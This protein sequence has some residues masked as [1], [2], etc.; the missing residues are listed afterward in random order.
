MVGIRYRWLLAVP[1][2]YEVVVLKT[3]KTEAGGNKA[4]LVR[5]PIFP[6]TPPA[7]RYCSRQCDQYWDHLFSCKFSKTPLHNAIQNTM[8]ILLST[9]APL[10]GLV[11]NKFDIL[12]EP[13]NLL[14]PMHPLRRPVDIAITLKSPTNSKSTLL[15]INVSTITPVPPH[16]HSQPQLTNTSNILEAHLSSIRGKLS[17]QTHGTLSNQDVITAINQEHITLH[18]RR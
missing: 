13:T 16:L 7:C 12:L 15:A 4:D 18:Q 5:L 6:A 10:S 2:Q 1:L 14:L 9:L 3:G 8:Y 11:H 17:G